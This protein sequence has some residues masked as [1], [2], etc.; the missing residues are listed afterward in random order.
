M[1]GMQ[2]IV[3][4]MQNIIH[5]LSIII[6]IV[7]TSITTTTSEKKPV[8]HE[9]NRSRHWFTIPSR[10]VVDENDDYVTARTG[11]TRWHIFI[12]TAIIT[13]VQTF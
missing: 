5:N 2:L 4:S 9:N 7:L 3:M 6:Q 12:V 1:I 8:A 13:L 11:D 10:Q